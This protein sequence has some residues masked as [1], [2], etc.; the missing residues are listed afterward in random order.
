MSSFEIFSW[1]ISEGETY[2]YIIYYGFLLHAEGAEEL[3]AAQHKAVAFIARRVVYFNSHVK[4]QDEEG[5]VKTEA[6][7]GPDSKFPVELIPLEFGVSVGNCLSSD[8]REAGWN[9]P[10]MARTQEDGRMD[11][12]E[13][14][15]AKCDAALDENDAG[16]FQAVVE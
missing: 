7:P 16:L 1:L 8:A 10:D 15:L 5:Q 2:P 12:A 6:E 13:E 9:C 11:A 4:A 3:S 14:L